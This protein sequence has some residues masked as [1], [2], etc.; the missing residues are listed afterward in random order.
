R[1]NRAP[2]ASAEEE[3]R[4][5]FDQLGRDLALAVIPTSDRPSLP[6]TELDVA[7]AITRRALRLRL[8]DYYGPARSIC[9]YR[10]GRPVPRSAILVADLT[11]WHEPTP[12]GQVSIDP[13]L[14]RI[15]FPARYPPEEEISV[16]CA[17]LG[18]GA[19]G[20]GSYQRPVPA[21]TV[22]VYPVGP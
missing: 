20:G 10:G 8:E 13:Q 11:R 15:A 17:R 14:G 7:G 19:I 3:H 1:V 21:A 12:D 2:A 6:A 4:Y 9:V 22:P 5:T 18:I 16:T